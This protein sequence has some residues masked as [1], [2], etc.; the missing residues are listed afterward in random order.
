MERI[1]GWRVDNI[2]VQVINL[3]YLCRHIETVALRILRCL[4]YFHIPRKESNV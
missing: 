1:L 3:F 4:N 2:I